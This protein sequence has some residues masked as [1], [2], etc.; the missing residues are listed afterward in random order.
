[1]LIAGGSAEGSVGKR[2]VMMG[3]NDAAGTPKKA[4]A[5]ARLGVH[6]LE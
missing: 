5:E 2:C 1:M 4:S 6:G 3:T